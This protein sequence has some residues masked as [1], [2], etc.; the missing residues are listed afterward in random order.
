MPRK[1]QFERVGDEPNDIYSGTY[2]FVG[3]SSK[4]GGK[5]YTNCS[6]MQ[7]LTPI[8]SKIEVSDDKTACTV[9]DYFIC[10]NQER[11]MWELNQKLNYSRITLTHL[12]CTTGSSTTIRCLA[13]FHLRKIAIAWTLGLAYARKRNDG[14]QTRDSLKLWLAKS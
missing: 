13:D 1:F 5:I 12:S 8:W 9:S 10:F 2:L 4:I 3:F 6:K 7:G 11:S 14:F